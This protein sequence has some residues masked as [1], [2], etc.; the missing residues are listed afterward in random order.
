MNEHKWEEEEEGNLKLKL[1][2]AAPAS[3]ER[4]TNSLWNTTKL[5]DE[6]FGSGRKKKK[7]QNS[8][9]ERTKDD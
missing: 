7:K 5:L 3:R 6:P 8:E 9:V 4:G 1:T 2:K